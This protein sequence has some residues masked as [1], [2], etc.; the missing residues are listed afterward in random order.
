MLQIHVCHDV[1]VQMLHD[2]MYEDL[3]SLERENLH[4]LWEF[5]KRRCIRLG[6]VIYG[7]RFGVLVSRKLPG[8]G[9]T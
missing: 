2:L 4:F 9:I 7:W 6:D 1:F 5:L 3:N 8:K